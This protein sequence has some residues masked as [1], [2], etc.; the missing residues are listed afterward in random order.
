MFNQIINQDINYI[1]EKKHINWSALKNKKFLISGANS[2]I[3]NYIIYLLIYLN[4]KIITAEKL[5]SNYLHI[6]NLKIH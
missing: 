3:A 2:F 4:T 1:L 6:H 5:K